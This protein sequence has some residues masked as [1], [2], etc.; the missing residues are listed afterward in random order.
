MRWLLAR[1]T[2]EFRDG[3]ADHLVHRPFLSLSLT[4]QPPVQ[5]SAA[6]QSGRSMNA[7]IVARLESSFAPS[8]GGSSDATAAFLEYQLV[9]EA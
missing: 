7:E 3:F 6:K 2:V 1:M 4:L 5:V 9:S 8:A